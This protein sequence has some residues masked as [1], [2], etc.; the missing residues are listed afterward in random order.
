[1]K[2]NYENERQIRL[3]SE[4]DIQRLREQLADALSSSKQETDNL[5]RAVDNM[6]FANEESVRNVNLKNEEIENLME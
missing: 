6:K 2:T 5:R 4:G 3:N 1:M